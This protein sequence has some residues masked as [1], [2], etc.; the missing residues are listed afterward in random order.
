MGS[1]QEI[2]RLIGVDVWLR[3]LHAMLMNNFQHQY[4]RLACPVIFPILDY[5]IDLFFPN[6]PCDLRDRR[7]EHKTQRMG[8][9]RE[10]T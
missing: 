9:E 10:I 8:I 3:Y 2:C 1:K 4:L 5:T 7:H 6:L